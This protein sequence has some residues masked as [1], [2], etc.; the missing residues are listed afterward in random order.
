MIIDFEVKG[1]T[2]RV[3]PDPYCWAIDKMQVAQKG[4]NEGQLTV[5]SI[6]YHGTF[7]QAV[8]YLGEAVVRNHQVDEILAELY[9][10]R[11]LVEEALD[12][13]REEKGVPTKAVVQDS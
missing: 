11:L 4:K 8:S 9:S 7:A 1:T 12:D 2:Y 6:T 5:A 13:M 3:R 10:L